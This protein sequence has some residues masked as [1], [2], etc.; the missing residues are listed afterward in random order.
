MAQTS[1]GEEEDVVT[2]EQELGIISVQALPHAGK[3]AASPSYLL[4][5]ESQWEIVCLG[6]CAQVCTDTYTLTSI[7]ILKAFPISTPTNI[8]LSIRD[9]K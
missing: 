8:Q 4:Q 3:L 1:T 7:H 9:R 2:S 6:A 5:P